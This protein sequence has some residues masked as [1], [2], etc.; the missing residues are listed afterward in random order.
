[1]L[2][3]RDGERVIVPAR[4]SPESRRGEVIHPDRGAGLPQDTGG[5]AL[6]QSGTAPVRAM[7]RERR[8]G[9]VGAAV[10]ARLGGAG[11]AQRAGR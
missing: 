5:G 7:R 10:R 9:R 11:R 3:A 4:G 2:R 6:G 8:R 1:M